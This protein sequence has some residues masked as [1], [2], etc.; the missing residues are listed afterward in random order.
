MSMPEEALARDARRGTLERGLDLLEYFATVGE[1]TPTEA[2]RANDLSRSATYRIISLL[3]DRGYLEPAP[4]ADAFRLGVKAVEIGTAALSGI[5]LVACAEPFLQDSAEA[6]AETSFLAV[7]DEPDMVYLARAE[8]ASYAMQL[9]ARLGT[10]RP[11]HATGLGKAF[12]SGLPRDEAQRLIDQLDFKPLT[13]NTI[14][15]PNQMTEELEAIRSRGYA[16]DNIE[17][18]PGVACFAAP[19]FDQRRRVVAAISLAGPAERILANE[20]K[21]GPL[22][23]ATADRI[24][25]RLGYRP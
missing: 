9:N 18:E 6:A 11:V 13:P 12:L 14:T 21:A 10:R 3:R 25:R 20:G 4:Q 8:G 22:I 2:S 16:I 5:E 1:A 7:F 15:D 17:N 24:S 19:I 23:A